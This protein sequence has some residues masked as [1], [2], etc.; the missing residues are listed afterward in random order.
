MKRQ[1]TVLTIALAL[2]IALPT[3]ASAETLTLY[4]AHDAWVSSDAPTT[5]TNDNWVHIANNQ[6][7]THRWSFFKFDLSS[8]PDNA[9]ITMAGFRL[10][11]AGSWSTAPGFVVP[12]DRYPQFF[13]VSDDSWS[14]ST[15]TW[16]N[17]PAYDDFLGKSYHGSS[18]SLS[19]AYFT[20]PGTA[21]N[22]NMTQ[23]LSDD[24]LS[25]VGR[26]P[27]TQE[28][29]ASYVGFSSEASGTSPQLYL[30][31]TVPQTPP[32]TVPEPSSF[33]LAGLGLFALF[34][35]RRKARS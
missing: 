11:A 24:F 33:A 20:Y 23:D 4:A 32:E 12:Y 17:M 2:L 19:T 34:L 15:L 29:S 5:N 18:F 26:I 35:Y 21:D 10:Y 22:W 6:N 7:T 1:M 13:H 9:A 31:Y 14:E 16:E 3:L 30:E 28:Y 25:I 8:V 27:D